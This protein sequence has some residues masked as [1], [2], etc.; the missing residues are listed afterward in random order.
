MSLYLKYRSAMR[1]AEKELARH[2]E[3][4]STDTDNDI[5]HIERYIH[6]RQVMLKLET[7]YLA[8]KAFELGIIVSEHLP[9]KEDWW[10]TEKDGNLADYLKPEGVV[11]LHQLIS[12]KR[13]Q[14][15]K[16]WID[17]FA[18]IISTIISILAL[19][20]AIIALNK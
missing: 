15:V 20:V 1:K 12:D 9:K 17:L 4:S 6:I 18:P 5:A 7:T 14:I 11:R 8:H 16:R 19:I 3:M 13:H 2:Y 10:A